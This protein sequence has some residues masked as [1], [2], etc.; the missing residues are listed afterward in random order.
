MTGRV[1]K[2]SYFHDHRTVS[3]DPWGRSPLIEDYEQIN[4]DVVAI[5]REHAPEPTLF[6]SGDLPPFT[7]SGV[8]PETLNRLPYTARHAAAA[9]PSRAAVLQMVEEYA[10]DPDIEFTH[11]GLDDYRH[12]VTRWIR[13]DD[14]PQP[15]M[16]AEEEAAIY[17]ELFGEDEKSDGPRPA[18]YNV[19]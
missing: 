13:G 6:E 10:D 5:E 19:R 9:E 12:R 3:I 4:P 16:N 11:R 8:D 2:T 1:D 7:A 18:G 17:T 15:E 14:R